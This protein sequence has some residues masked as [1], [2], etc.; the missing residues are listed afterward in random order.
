[1]S[2]KLFSIYA[3]STLKALEAEGQ[4]AELRLA[5]QPGN[6]SRSEVGEE[7]GAEVTNTTD[8][9]ASNNMAPNRE[10]LADPTELVLVKRKTNQRKR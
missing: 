6:Q 10:D 4:P 9:N 7:P 5:D 2:A 3:F 1:M 8:T